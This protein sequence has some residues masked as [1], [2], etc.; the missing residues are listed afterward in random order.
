MYT[1][2]N[3]AFGRRIILSSS[4]RFVYTHLFRLLSGLHNLKIIKINAS[5]STTVCCQN[6]YQTFKFNRGVYLLDFS[7]ISKFIRAESLPSKP[8]WNELNK[9]FR[10]LQSVSLLG[11]FELRS[12]VVSVLPSVTIGTSLSKGFLC[13]PYFWTEEC[14]P[15]LFGSLHGFPRY[16]STSECEPNLHTASVWLTQSINAHLCSKIRALHAFLS[17]CCVFFRNFP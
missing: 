15:D 1:L 4:K 7:N 17:F 11:S 10:R 8:R 14:I 5:V 2:A 16:C 6:Q 3:A 13:Y 12:S 9:C